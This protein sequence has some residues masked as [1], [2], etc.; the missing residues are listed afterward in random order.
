[1]TAVAIGAVLIAIASVVPFS[2]ET[3][4]AK[5]IAVLS[6]RLQGE[7]ELQQ[8]HVRVL[9]RLRAD[10]SGLTIRHKG[11]RDV[12]PLI[13]IKHFSAEGNVPGLLRRHLARLTIEGLD[14][15]IP[16]DRNREPDAAD[17]EHPGQPKRSHRADAARG[18][19]ID[20]L[21]STDGRLVIIPAEDDKEP[22]VWDIHRLR[23][24]SVAVDAAMPF[25]ATLT[26]AVPPGEIETVGTFGPWHA[27]APGRTPLAGSF[28]FNRADLG[29]F[30]GISGILSARG[31]FAG[32]LVRIDIHGET[33]TPQF[34]VAASGHPVP[35]HAKYHAIVDGTNGNTILDQVDGSFLKTSLVAKG[36]VVET[37]GRHGRTVTL[38]VTMDQARLE[39]VLRLAVKSSTAP[40]TGAL[41]LKTT[42]LLPP[43][44]LDVVKKLRLDGRFAISGARFTHGDVQRKINELSHR[45]RG[46]DPEEQTQRIASQFVG[47]FK[48]G[49]GILTIPEV[50]FDVPGSA[51]RL[52]GTY[53]LLHETL[54][55]SGTLFMDAKVSETTTG[56]KSILLKIADPLFKWEGG[57]SAIPIKITG[58]RDNP[59]FGLDKGRVFKRK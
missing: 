18:L 8:F 4:R 35:L 24:M 27:E 57:G 34:T 9:P 23:M 6:D 22:K 55:F 26:N 12:P 37:P 10:G 13:S 47:T 3:A 21:E 30:K 52:A 29:V 59:S 53:D 20:E 25:E 46:K 16:P 15:E 38:D 45:G 31:T 28:T 5:V 19:L 32:A 1:M 58:S 51:V 33:D 36:G 14:I 49:D 42:F 7:V 40:M 2:S 39:D 48:L 17:A 11:R 44:D 54:D 50:T 43:G 56:F 41:K